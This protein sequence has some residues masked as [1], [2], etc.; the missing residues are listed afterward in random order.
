MKI[1]T[2]SSVGINI[3]KRYVTYKK[4]QNLELRNLI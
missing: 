4:I 3:P 2:F 1:K